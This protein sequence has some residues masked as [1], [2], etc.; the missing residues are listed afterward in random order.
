M[1]TSADHGLSPAEQW[2]EIEAI[3]LTRLRVDPLG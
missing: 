3:N 1:E 2:L